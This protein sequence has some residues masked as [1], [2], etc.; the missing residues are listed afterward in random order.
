MEEMGSVSHGRWCQT[1]WWLCS[2][3][4]CGTIGQATERGGERER[5]REGEGERGREEGERERGGTDD[6]F[7]V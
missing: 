2:H 6:G 5:G 3:L 7:L 1:K 4:A